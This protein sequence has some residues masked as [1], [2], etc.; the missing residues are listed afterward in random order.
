MRVFIT[1]LCDGMAIIAGV[2]LILMA[3][4]TLVDVIMRIFG[5]PVPGTYEI[6]MYMGV[7]VTGFALP[8]ASMKKAN[9]FVDL[10]V[11]KLSKTPQMILKVITR[12]LV[13]IMFLITAYYFIQ[14]G[15]S[16]VATKSVTM[17]LR[18]PFYP[19]VF[20]M[21]VSCVAQSFVSIYDIF[22][23]TGGNNNE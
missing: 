16:F 19:V 21:A 10:L 7:A 5:S 3:I 6:V 15:M 12:L 2:V 1:R 9:V 11:E 22:D 20:G 8:R 23:N 4:I 14:M 17:T 13:C 18:V